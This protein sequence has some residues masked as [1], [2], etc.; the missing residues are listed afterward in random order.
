MTSDPIGALLEGH[1][2][3]INERDARL[4]S[5]EQQLAAAN[6][7]VEAVAR[8]AKLWHERAEA[9]QLGH[10]YQCSAIRGMERDCHCGWL[11]LRQITRRSAL[12]QLPGAEGA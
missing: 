12:S 4:A 8:L 7:R 9:G 2:E 10:H 5:L 6:A 1:R 11:S 3:Q